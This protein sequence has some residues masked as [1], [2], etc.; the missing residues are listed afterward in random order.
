M[1]EEVVERY[2][3]LADQFG[4][5]VEA[6]PDEAWDRPAPCEGWTARD[7]LKHV[8][9][10][11]RRG[12][13]QLSG[14]EGDPP[15]ASTEDPKAL[16]RESYAAFKEAMA[17][18]G[19]M[20]KQVTGPMGPMPAEMIVGRFLATDVLVHTWD[21]ARAVGGDEKLDADA[22]SQAYKGL[23][24]MDAMI[25]QPGVFGAKV[26]PAADADEQEQFLNF[27]GRITR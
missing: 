24:P 1:A 13:W 19:A 5:R 10:S 26:E 4:E 6:T 20:A 15:P 7:V 16:W 27:L 18:P 12:A 11:Q 14:N 25:R 2:T 23:Q 8:T 21:L 17:Q 3:K 9:D 22:V